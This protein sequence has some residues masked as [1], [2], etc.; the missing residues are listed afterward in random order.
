MFA[1]A[2]TFHQALI[3]PSASD[4][5]RRC[6]R[7]A[8]SLDE[9]VA[10]INAIGGGQSHSL[11]RLAFT[12]RRPPSQ[13]SKTNNQHGGEGKGQRRYDFDEALP[14]TLEAAGCVGVPEGLGVAEGSGGGLLLGGQPGPLLVI[15]W[16]VRSCIRTNLISNG[17]CA[18]ATITLLSRLG[19]R[20]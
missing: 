4:S 8:L 16:R 19:L 1:C 10:Q 9:E 6:W 14:R 7:S 13:H 5:G 17:A 3:L 18:A 20:S 15:G 11:E 12:C 2:R